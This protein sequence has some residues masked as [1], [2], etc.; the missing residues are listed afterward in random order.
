VANWFTATHPNSPFVSHL[1]AARAGADGARY[2]LFNGRLSVR[3]TPDQVERR[4]L[5][6]EAEYKGTLAGTFTLSLSSADLAALMDTLDRKGTRG[7][8]HPFFA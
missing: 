2:S 1:I 6:G 3:H 7:A 4:L 5:D 8:T